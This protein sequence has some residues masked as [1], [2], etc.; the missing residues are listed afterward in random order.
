MSAAL[1]AGAVLPA[2]L[3]LPLTLPAS[4]IDL[5]RRIIP[6][7]LNLA[8]LLLGLAVAGWRDGASGIGLGLA[9]AGLAYGLFWTLRALH[10]RASG[11]IGLGLGDVKFIAAASAWTGL[12]GLPVLILAASLSALAIIGLLALAGR[13]IGRETA[14]PFG[15]FL[16]FGLHAALLIGPAG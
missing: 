1:L 2:L 8:L 14:L 15:P 11:R 6:D 7:A 13:A 5:R 3:P 9:Q 4:W 12:A 10:A 16:A